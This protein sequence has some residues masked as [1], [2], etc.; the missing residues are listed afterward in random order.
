MEAY[1]IKEYLRST[2]QGNIARLVK[3]FLNT[4]ST[5]S[6][7]NYLSFT[8]YTR[9]KKTMEIMDPKGPRRKYINKIG[10]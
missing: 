4:S 10:N 8:Y 7:I 2:F 6:T 9:T 1:R 3:G 5:K